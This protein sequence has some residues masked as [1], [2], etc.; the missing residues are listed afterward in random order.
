MLKA[1]LGIGL[2]SGAGA[3]AVVA[4]RFDCPTLDFCGVDVLALCGETAAAGAV[5]EN[6]CAT[7]GRL[8]DIDLKALEPGRIAAFIAMVCCVWDE[9]QDVEPS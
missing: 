5:V 8:L 2:A 4:G 9:R 6:G 3:A 7:D 1:G